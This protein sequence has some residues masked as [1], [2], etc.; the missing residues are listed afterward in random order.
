MAE[1][2]PINTPPAACEP[3]ALPQAN[4]DQ[5]F[6]SASTREQGEEKSDEQR[7]KD[8]AARV[9]LESDLESIAIPPPAEWIAEQSW[10]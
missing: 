5:P 10:E 7:R 9:P 3:V 8:A 4:T 6:S 2:N 1:Q